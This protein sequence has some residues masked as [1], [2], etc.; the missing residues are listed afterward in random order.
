MA[1]VCGQYY[2]EISG[3]PFHQTV[4]CLNCDADRFVVVWIL[5]QSV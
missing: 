5:Y 2:E 1:G 4:L 3:T